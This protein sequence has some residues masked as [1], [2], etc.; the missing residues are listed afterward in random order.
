M[1][2][3]IELPLMYDGDVDLLNGFV[4]NLDDFFD[5]YGVYVDSYEFGVR[6]IA[7]S[8]EAGTTVKINCFN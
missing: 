7:D 5:V 2:M 1:M 8:I 6:L 4:D 3:K